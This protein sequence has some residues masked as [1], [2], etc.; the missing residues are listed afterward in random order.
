MGSSTRRRLMMMMVLFFAS[1]SS[2]WWKEAFWLKASPQKQAFFREG[3]FSQF[4]VETFEATYKMEEKQGS[5]FNHL[6]SLH[7]RLLEPALYV[8]ATT[9][10]LSVVPAELLCWV[11]TLLHKAMQISSYAKPFF[12]CA[13]QP[14]LWQWRKS[15]YYMIN[16]QSGR[17]TLKR[18]KMSSFPSHSFFYLPW[19]SFSINWWWW[20]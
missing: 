10:L 19:T 18:Q 3:N 4:S 2:V 8:V 6:P 17:K 9:R 15:S 13:P 14:F 1:H 16:L 5:G 12:C 20:C 7:F 11:D